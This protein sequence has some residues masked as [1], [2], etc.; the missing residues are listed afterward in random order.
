MFINKFTYKVWCDSE[1]QSWSPGG[2]WDEN[3]FGQGNILC[4]SMGAES[5]EQVLETIT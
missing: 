3:I 1:G 2:Q 4:Q 5:V